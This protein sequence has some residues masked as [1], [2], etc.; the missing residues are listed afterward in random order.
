MTAASF[1]CRK[2]AQ[3][4]VQMQGRYNVY[5]SGTMTMYETVING[6]RWITKEQLGGCI[7]KMHVPE[8]LYKQGRHLGL[9]GNRLWHFYWCGEILPARKRKRA[10][11]LDRGIVEDNVQAGYLAPA[12]LPRRIS[13]VPEMLN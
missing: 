2:P 10:V 11:D 5:S 7:Q 1:H 13:S 3:W 4:Q 6:R 8:D 9:T 12:Q